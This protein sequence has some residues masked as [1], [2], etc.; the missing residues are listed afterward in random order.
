MS[1]DLEFFQKL[2]DAIKTK[3]DFFNSSELPK[4]LESYRLLHTC[5]RNLYDIL[6]KRSLITPDPY[7]LE[8]KISDITIPDESPF[9]ESERALIIGSRFSDY[10][11]MLDFICTYV[12]FS[13]D[14]ITIPR[15]KKLVDLNNS[16]Q[17]NNMTMNNSRTNTRGLALLIQEAKENAPKLQTSLINDS[18]SK[19][20]QSVDL[21]NATLK[22]LMTFQRE[23][24]KF[25]I[26]TDILQSPKFNKEKATTQAE[27]IAEIKKIFPSIMGK[28]SYYG[29]LIQEIAAEDLAPNKQKIQEETLYKLQ[30]KQKENKEK[31]NSVDYKGILLNCLHTLSN[32]G[33][34]YS[35]II[36]KLSANVNILEK[37][38]NSF[39]KKLKKALRAAF[40][41]PEPPLIYEL[42]ITDQKKGTKSR[43][44]V[45]INVFSANIER[46]ANFFI[47]LSDKRGPEFTK[48]KLLSEQKILEYLNKSIT[49]NQEI[50]VLLDALDE[51]FKQQVNPHDRSKIKG[52][53][54]DLISIKNILIKAVQQRSEYVSYIEEQEQMQKL[55]IK[56]EE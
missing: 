21:I 34:L 19:S 3:K 32:L 48:A 1:E 27:E 44:N 43:R 29:E 55:G 25:Q 4:M 35:A 45:D 56:N 6:V 37:Q 46:K 52:L 5:V 23:A 51:F 26:R 9:I 17:W 18:V 54:I 40:K 28:T 39:F 47:S 22:E 30:I 38:K 53:K 11:S 2:K 33:E 20:S 31:Q 42:T 24:Y 13:T 15:I 36:E 41:I 10:E 50:L 12:K 16:F 8:S 49:E 7:K 14:G